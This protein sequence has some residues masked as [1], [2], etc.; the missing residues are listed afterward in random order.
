M[1]RYQESAVLFRGLGSKVGLA[2]SLYNLGR[3]TL[4]EGDTA[5]AL[6]L[7]TESVTLFHE[8]GSKQ[9]LPIV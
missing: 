7:F 3:V 4:D 8:Q 6:V 1:A 2:W 5:Q 9:V